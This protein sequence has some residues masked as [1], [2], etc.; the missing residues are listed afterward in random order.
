MRGIQAARE[1]ERF[2]EIADQISLSLHCETAEIMTRLHQARRGGGHADRAGGLQRLAPAALRGPRGHHRVLPRPRDRAAQHQPAA[3]DVAQGDRG[4]DAD[5]RDVPA[6]RLPPR[7]HR[8]PPARRLPHRAR[9]GGKVNPPLRP[10]EDVEAL[11]EHLLAG[12]FDWVVSDHACCKDETKFGEPARRRLRWPSPASAAPS[13]SCPAWSARAA[14][15]GCPTA[16]SPSCISRNPA[17]RF[18]LP[19]KGDIAVGFDA[20]FCLVDDDVDW[21]SCAPRTRSPRRSTRRSRGSS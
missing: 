14:S 12:N 18:G 16:G 13:T 9:L 21:T 8:R 17:D 1:D 2:A 10:R 3:P 6:R 20:D 11:W 5:G 4:G 15:A 7:G 19:T